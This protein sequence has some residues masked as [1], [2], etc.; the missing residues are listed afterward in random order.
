M[1]AANLHRGLRHLAMAPEAILLTS[2]IGY[3]SSSTTCFNVS[4]RHWRTGIAQVF[5]TAYYL[6]DRLGRGA[7]KYLQK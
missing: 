7:M 5:T 3:P 4:K 2:N 1:V 6:D